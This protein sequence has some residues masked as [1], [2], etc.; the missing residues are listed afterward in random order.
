MVVLAITGARDA[1]RAA[2]DAIAVKSVAAIVQRRRRVPDVTEK[3]LRAQA[4]ALAKLQARGLPLLPVRFGTA[5]R[6]E[7]ELKA[8]L[9]P[10]ADALR[11]ALDQTRGKLQMTVR[12]RGPRK[13]AP[14]TSGRAFL[15]ARAR[16]FRV[17]A[18][19]PVRKAVRGL[20]AAEETDA[21]RGAFEGAV[22]HL[23]E[24]THIAA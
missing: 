21:A 18:A 12:V 2:V 24:E 3:T 11:D 16:E 22:H 7:D 13:D 19:D 23:V 1:K 6:D 8:L 5:V 4:A 15:A 20:V 10:Q 17:P 14:R 9:K